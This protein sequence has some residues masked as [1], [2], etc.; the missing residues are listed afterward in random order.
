MNSKKVVLLCYYFP[1]NTGVG[2]RRW[3]K[4]CKYL[5]KQQVEFTVFTPQ[6]FL[7]KNQPSWQFDADQIPNLKVME[8]N[9]FFPK[10][11]LDVPES[12]IGK[13]FYR[14]AKGYV[15]L[16]TKGNKYDPSAFWSSI[17]NKNVKNF[18]SENN[19]HNI[20]V[21]GIPFDFFYYAA[22]LKLQNPKLN[23][24]LDFRDLWTDSMG[25]YGENVRKFQSEKRFENECQKERFA[26]EQSDY[27][28]C[29]SDDLYSILQSKYPEHIEKFKLIL[30]GFDPEEILSFVKKDTQSNTVSAGKIKI[31]NIGTINC[32][33][34]YYMHL[35][36]AL[37]RIKIEDRSLFE[38]LQFDF[39]GNANLQFE[40]DMRLSELEIISFH[41]KVDSNKVQELIQNADMVLYIKREEELAN[42]FASKFFEYL[43]AGKFMIVL[44]PEGKVTEYVRKNEIGLVLTK[45]LIYNNLKDL[46]YNFN[47][48]KVNFNSDLDISE[49]GYDKISKKI[50]GLLK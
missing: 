25:S 30:N 16:F 22:K 28:L 27:V 36:E 12:V 46:F 24:I 47:L 23:L 32:S 45:E 5:S 26:L 43:S 34:D 19:V 31:I 18:M 17:I 7:L 1:P 41:D 6:K 15:R 44:S 10:I 50:E 8:V 39:Y 33:R 49:F 35:V 29:A 4:F 2:G 42:S 48:G 20:I 38:Q 14:F 3:V 37:K 11:L 9:D 21:S 40:K 13:I